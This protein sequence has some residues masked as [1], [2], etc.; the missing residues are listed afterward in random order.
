[1]VL[2]TVLKKKHSLK[3]VN[4]LPLIKRVRTETGQLKEYV[5]ILTSKRTEE[6]PLEE[7]RGHFEGITGED[8]R[9][10]LKMCDMDF[11]GDSYI[12]LLHHTIKFATK[13]SRIARGTFIFIAA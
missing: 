10:I 12:L 2:L 3:D 11:T 5:R 13:G 7:L 1:M 4:N 8:S 9:D 6:M